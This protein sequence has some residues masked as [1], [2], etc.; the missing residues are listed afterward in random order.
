M[1]AGS[2]DGQFFIWDRKTTNIIK[3]LRGDESIV[4]CLQPHPTTC[5]LATSGIDK[6]IRYTLWLSMKTVVEFHSV[7]GEIQWI[8]I[9]QYEHARGFFDIL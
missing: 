9:S 5:F 6:E 3:I 8:F 2:D 7:S 4:N 1:I